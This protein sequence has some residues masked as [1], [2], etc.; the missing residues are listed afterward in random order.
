M[1][2]RTALLALAVSCLIPGQVRAQDKGAQDKDVERPNPA[3]AAPEAP[4]LVSCPAGAPLG[5]V[6]LK[7]E[8][9]G[10]ETLPFR[11]INH[12]SEGDTVRYA[13]VLR[14]KEARPGEIA[15]VLVPEK[16][17]KGQ[18]EILVTDP[19]PANKPQ[20]WRMTRT[21]SVAA[22]VYGPA[23]L[24]RKK[25]AR[26]LSQD[27]VMIAQ[28]ADYADKTS[29]AEQLVA[30]LSN[31]EASAAS[32]NAALNGFASEYGLAVQINKG[33]PLAS[34]A[35]TLFAA[36]NPQLA[37]YNP[38]A[39]STAVRA[40]ETASLATTAATLFFGSPV[41][42]AA[43]GTAMLLDLR[44]IAFPDTQF[45]A[46]FATAVKPG[47]RAASDVNLCGQQ[48][49]APA[50]TRVAYLWASRIPNTAAPVIKIGDANFIPAKEKTPVPVE[51]GEP[52]WK[53]LD[54]VRKWT[55]IDARKKE[56]PIGVVTLGNRKAL[57]IDLTKA[58]IAPG[59]YTLAGFWD[60]THFEAA[61]TIHVA[62]LNDFTKSAVSEKSRERLLVNAGRIPVTI[63][64]GD[65]EFA[66]K[67]ELQ[68]TG[69]EFATPEA[70]RFLL[71]KG[72]RKGPQDRMDVQVDTSGL[73]PGAY[74]M[75][76]AQ[77]AAKKR[78]VNFEILPNPPAIGNL[79]VIVNQGTAEQHFVLKG[80]RL[81]LIAKM[82]APG[83]TFS[84]DP[85]EANGT[86]RSLTV[87]LGPSARAGNSVPVQAILADRS[88]TLTFQDGIEIT[89][90]L[91]AIVSSRLS[92][93]TGMQISLGPDEFPAGVTLNAM[94]DVKNIERGSLL[95]LACADGV[96]DPAALHIGEDTG[97]SNLQQ[98]SRDQLFLAFNTSSLPAGCSLEAAI[99][100]GREGK[101]APY[102]LA[103]ILRLPAID[104]LTLAAPG[105]YRLTGTNLE[106]IA[107]VAWDGGQA[108][109]VGTL[110]APVPGQGLKQTVDVRMPDPPDP[111]AMLHVWLREDG[112]GRATAI[113][114]P[115][116]PAPDNQDGASQPA[117]AASQ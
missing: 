89:G 8:A 75:L 60:W 115:A 6:D 70:V 71:P 90:P 102:V 33:A 101:S 77:G 103:R 36:M 107:K 99:D 98:L 111:Q 9:A 72:L 40:G 3:A 34:Q 56:I 42:L 86:E 7:V 94:L 93:P 91:P 113:Q 23:G 38:L 4:P 12:L 17:E 65:F 50:H 85:A 109:E 13:P 1:S 11:T 62:E 100:N 45:R 30:T 55:L 47:D 82:Q 69:D 73:A 114:A 31:S 63:E 66:T 44:A 15:L 61:G 53:Y 29:Q 26:F 14:G 39:S 74:E 105:T 112:A 88:D 21:I 104:S 16:I 27:E 83:V 117:A 54:R 79:P 28:L 10:S 110:P 2:L 78:Q 116:L 67:V 37:I 20:D 68:K 41:G 5:K 52:V 84:L 96:G 46:S 58:K 43:G 87:E 80:E 49:A 95:R 48:G 57:E 81:G 106:M 32:V 108:M 51:V 76:I 92:L 18:P 24:N 97:S 35:Q 25:V 22:L 59:D 64:G 19:R